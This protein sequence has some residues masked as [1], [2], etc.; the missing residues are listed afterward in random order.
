[1]SNEVAPASDFAAIV[2]N[3]IQRE[4]IGRMV[5]SSCR[6]TN[7]LRI[8]RVVGDSPLPPVL[9]MNAGVRTADELDVWVD[10]RL[11]QGI[12]FM[13]PRFAAKTNADAID[14]KSL[15]AEDA[16][17]AGAAVY[18]LRVCISTMIRGTS[19]AD[20]SSCTGNGSANSGRWRAA[21]F[22]GSC[23]R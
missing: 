13:T 23:S 22:G 6:Q 21:A 9:V 11:G 10:N 16:V 14:V 15:S 18:E 3:S 5:C 7:H 17:P 19:D 8:K 2:R 1:M 20:G 4:A 12:R